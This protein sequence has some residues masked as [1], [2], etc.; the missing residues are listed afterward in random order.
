M[1]LGITPMHLAVLPALLIT[2]FCTVAECCDFD[3]SPDFAEVV[4]TAKSVVVVRVEAVALDDAY[5]DVA[6]DPEDSAGVSIVFAPTATAKVRV[7]ETLVGNPTNLESVGYV[8]TYCGGHHLQVGSYYVA[9]LS[10]DEPQISLRLGSNTMLGLGNE[11]VEVYGAARSKSKLI[12][13]LLAFGQTGIFPSEKE[14]STLPFRALVEAPLE[15]PSG[16]MDR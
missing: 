13:N 5:S 3:P 11:F 6:A 10:T 14:F 1:A 15:F 4:L 7:A 2:G 16:P 12:K 9:A 8:V